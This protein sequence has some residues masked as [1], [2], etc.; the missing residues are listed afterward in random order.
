MTRQTKNVLIIQT[1][2]PDN[3]GESEPYFIEPA[4]HWNWGSRF[5]RK[6]LEGKLIEN[7]WSIISS[8]IHRM[9]ANVHDWDK[10]SFSAL[11]VKNLDTVYK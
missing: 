1:V 11:C 5:N 10:L 3:I 2:I 9:N 7:G 8:N 4:P 6:W